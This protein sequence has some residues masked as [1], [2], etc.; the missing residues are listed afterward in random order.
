MDVRPWIVGVEVMEVDGRDLLTTRAV[1][2]MRRGEMT[3]LEE[4]E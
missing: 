1:M 2:A 3:E 4:M